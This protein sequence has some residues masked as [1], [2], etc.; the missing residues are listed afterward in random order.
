MRYVNT[1]QINRANVSTLKPAWIFHTGVATDT[2]SNENQPI[3]VNGT[4]YISSPHGHVYALDGTTGAQKWVYSPSLPALSNLALPAGQLNRGVAYGN[5]M[6]FIGEPDASLLALDANTG[7]QVWKVQTQ[8]YQDKWTQTMAPLFVNGKVL[9]GGTGGEYKVRGNVSAYDAATGK[10]LWRFNT[11]PGP[12]EFGN[13]TWAGDSWKTGGAAVWSSPSADPALGLVYFV[14]GNPAPDENGSNRAGINL[15]SDCILA[16]DINTGAYKWHFQEV[17]HD[18]WDYDANQP[19]HL[20][21]I[22]K[23]GNQIP[24]IGHANKNGNYFILDRRTGTPIYPVTEVPVP[25]DVAWQ[26]AWPTQPKPFTPALIPQAVESTPAGLKSGPIWT[27][28]QETPILIQPGYESGPEWTP[29]AFSPRTNYAYLQSGGYEPWISHA[30]PS[31]VTSFGSTSNGT[32]PG[33]NNYGLFNAVDT[34]TGLIAWQK[35]FP[36]KV[37]SGVVVAGDLVFFGESNG[38]FDALDSKTGDILWSYKPT[39]PNTGGANA[40]PAVYMINGTEYV[41]MGFGG[42]NQLR[43]KNQK[44]SQTGDVV[45]AFALPSVSAALSPRVV[46]GTPV[47]VNT[48]AIPAS[49]QFTPAKAATSG[50]RQIVVTGHDFNYDPKNIVALAGERIAVRLVNTDIA[51]IGLAFSLPSGPIGFN[52][53]LDPGTDGYMNFTAPAQPGL[54]D[55][56]SPTQNQKFL[57]V[58]GTLRVAAACPIGTSP[59]L[60]SIGV[61][62]SASLLPGSV[63]PGEVITLFGLG[64]GPD[65]G[66]VYPMNATGTVSSTLAGTQVLFDGVAAPLIYVQTNQVNAIVPFSVNGKTSTN[67]TVSSNGATTNAIPVAVVPA[68]PGVFTASGT[69]QGQAVVLN[70]DGS[71]NG[72]SL[73]AAKGS[74]IRIFVTGDGVPN[75]VPADGARGASGSP[76]QQINVLIGGINAPVVAA[77]IAPDFFAGVLEID[78]TVPP[79]APSGL[80]IGLKVTVGNVFS[81]DGPTIAVR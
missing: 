70:A 13:D 10:Q 43:Q 59:C 72:A 35:R 30:I 66:Q 39:E 54:Y 5:G 24:A 75:P 1:D 28:V 9:I 18:L 16:L 53:P 44:T 68:S 6:V 61:S 21:T 60:S 2:S 31:E 76:T 38:T 73:N 11:V 45:V 40:C 80:A 32:V 48:G 65:G 77:K 3:V 41:V 67:I 22:A 62:N 74:T 4:V 19:P 12:G 51:P 63:A 52:M 17:H 34:T 55:M 64:L 50:Y 29:S 69:G 49:S 47:Q 56:F 81:P 14:T 78:A 15:F 26:H 46:N 57:G 58:T 20:F 23:N 27:V 37:L 36:E 33:V 79:N 42:N 7:A 8:S 25:T 71:L